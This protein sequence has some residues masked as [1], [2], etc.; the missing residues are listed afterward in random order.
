MGAP[1]RADSCAGGTEVARTVC[2]GFWGGVVSQT[3]LACP[4]WIGIAD[5]VA[6]EGTS[7][8]SGS[9]QYKLIGLLGLDDYYLQAG[10]WVDAW[11]GTKRVAIQVFADEWGHWYFLKTAGS[12]VSVQVEIRALLRV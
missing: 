12:P 2:V 3:R 4:W 8:E 1:G 11:M 9:G 10:E 6:V 5:P 7:T